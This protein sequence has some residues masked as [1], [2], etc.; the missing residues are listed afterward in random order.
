[1]LG[2]PMHD[3]DA[4]ENKRSLRPS[5]ADARYLRSYKAKALLSPRV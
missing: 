4:T 3:Q 2:V 1:M 5:S